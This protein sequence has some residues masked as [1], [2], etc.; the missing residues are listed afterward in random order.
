MNTI[1]FGKHIKNIKEHYEDDSTFNANITNW[2][3]VSDAIKNDDSNFDGTLNIDLTNWNELKS[4]LTGPPGP[5]GDAGAP[6]RRRGPPGDTGSQGIQG[7]QGPEGPEG[8]QG[9]KGDT[10]PQGIQ[11]PIGSQ[12]PKGPEGPKGP[13]GESI[14][15]DV[16]NKILRYSYGSSP[17]YTNLYDLDNLKGIQGEDGIIGPQGPPGPRGIQGEDGPQGPPGNDV[18]IEVR[19]KILTLI[20]GEDE[21]ELLDLSLIKGTIGIQGEAGVDGKN[22]NLQ[23]SEDNEF[24]QWQ[25]VGDMYWNNLINLNK[26]RG[27]QGTQGER[28]LQGIQGE[29]GPR[30]FRGPQGIQ[31]KDGPRGFRGPQ[32]IPGEEGSQ[33]ERGPQGIQGIQ[34]KRGIPGE[35]GPMGL[36]G[37]PGRDGLSGKDGLPGKDGI[38]GKEGPP[39]PMGPIGN[40]GPQGNV[41]PQG[42]IGSQGIPGEDGLQGVQ[43]PQ[44]P[45]G[46]QGIPGEDGKDGIRGPQG[47]EGPQGPR[48]KE[49][50]V[51]RQ[52]EQG[53]PGKD[54]SLRVDQEEKTLMLVQGEDE[55][56]LLKLDSIKGLQGIK[57]EAGKDGKNINLQ[58]AEENDSKYVQWQNVDDGNN[59]NNLINLD[60]LAGPQ[61]PPGTDGSD[62]NDG[63]DGKNLTF[64]NITENNGNVGIGVNNPTSKLHILGETVFQ[65]SKN[66]SHFN[67]AGSAN[68]DTYIRP[69]K[70]EGKVIMDVGN[71]GIGV[72]SNNANAKLNVSGETVFQGSKNKSHFN[73]AGSANEDTYIRPGKDEGKVIIDKGNVGIGVS[74]ENTNAK[75]NVSGDVEF[76][77]SQH[78]THFNHNTNEDTYIRPGKDEGKVIMDVGNVGIGTSNPTEKL[79]VS[80][81]A[82]INGSLMGKDSSKNSGVYF[83]LSH[84]DFTGHNQILMRDSGDIY[85]GSKKGGEISFF[86]GNPSVRDNEFMRMQNGNVGI[87]KGPDDNYKL[88]VDGHIRSSGDI[89]ANEIYGS[90]LFIDNQEIK[91]LPNIEN[92]ING[93]AINGSIQANRYL[94]KDGNEILPTSMASSQLCAGDNCLTSDQITRLK[95]LLN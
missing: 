10:G 26:I 37:Y 7:P 61:G 51:G 55:T 29:D 31:G 36:Q 66:K 27:L 62:G 35:D 85:M 20:S 49:G 54:V 79:D 3:D 8:A 73:W 72:S 19:N 56:E 81:N 75:L 45:Q 24:I 4:E 86:N 21:K 16:N 13:I 12:G 40:D 63:D 44:G 38:Q 41:G 5:P 6:S 84:K 47:R 64:Q 78:I 95:G 90:K 82:V 50:P 87:G 39:G 32:G 2:K 46:F 80:G 1:F 14:K 68:E 94:D 57:G 18:K 15:L 59:W 76:K 58:I 65:G 25:N 17:I 53:I 22:I 30:G 77:G 89:G 83:P 23:L 34:G 11:G 33:G 74:S 92:T 42:P 88:D 70:D 43:G 52:G 67:W 48:G 71:V 9:P 93:V 60:Q 69:G 91:P 28:G